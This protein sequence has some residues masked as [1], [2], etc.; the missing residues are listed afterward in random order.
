MFHNPQD[1][2]FFFRLLNL[3]K[4][5]EVRVM[6]QVTT[7]SQRHLEVWLDL[8]KRVSEVLTPRP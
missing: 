7:G 5:C 4:G 3:I 2:N 8:V 6:G 1:L